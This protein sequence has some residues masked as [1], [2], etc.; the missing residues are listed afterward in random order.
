M[1]GE[2]STQLAVTDELAKARA[3]LARSRAQVVV[4]AE[5]L[6]DDLSVLTQWKTWAARRPYAAL[7]IAFGVGVWLGTMGRRK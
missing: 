3:D 1:A 6:R 5:A 4:A 7:G 2:L